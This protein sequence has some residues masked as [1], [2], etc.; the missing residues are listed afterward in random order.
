[1][2]HQDRNRRARGTGAIGADDGDDGLVGGE[3]GRGSLTTF[4]SATVILTVELDGMTEDF[5]AGIIDG[6][7]GA[8]FGI[9]TEGGVIAGSDKGIGDVDGVIRS[10]VDAT[11]FVGA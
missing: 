11:E 9:E 8:V 5:A 2:G 1:M 4:W 6:E 7:F 3:F 10:D